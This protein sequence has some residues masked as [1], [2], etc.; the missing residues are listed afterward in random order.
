MSTIS[1]TRG[2]DKNSFIWPVCHLPFRDI[3]NQ[4]SLWMGFR[5]YQLHSPNVIQ[6][7]Q[8][9]WNRL[10]AWR[11][12]WLL[13]CDYVSL[14]LNKCL[15]VLSSQFLAHRLGLEQNVG[16]NYYVPNVSIDLTLLVIK[17]WIYFFFV[18]EFVNQVEDLLWTSAS[19][20]ACM[21]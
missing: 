1:C 5:N 12:T 9:Q 15:F 21:W 20:V 19:M 7:P 8:R 13:D 14:Y 6:W 11:W 2:V 17:F 16:G 4:E 18:V 10:S 3:W